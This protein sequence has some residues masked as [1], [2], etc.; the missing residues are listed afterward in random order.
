VADNSRV[1]D[2]PVLELDEAL[3]SFAT[4][5]SAA[6]GNAID[7]LGREALGGFTAPV[8]KKNL[9]FHRA[10]LLLALEPAKRSWCLD[11][12]I[13]KLP[14]LLDGKEHSSG[15]KC[16]ALVERLEVLAKLEPDPRVARGVLAMLEL[17]APVAGFTIVSEAASKAIVRHA[18]D[19]TAASP[20]LDELG[21]ELDRTKLPKPV[22]LDATVRARASA[23]ERPAKRDTAALF[24]AVYASP[25]AD[26]PREVLA[27]ALQEAGD[28]RGEFIALQLREARGDTSDELR[29]RAQ[30]LAKEHG[31][32][33]LGPLRP[34]TYRAEMRRGFVQRLE[35]AGSWSTNKWEELATE[36][37]LATV[38]EL[39][40]GQAT[41]AVYAK[42]LAGPIART[43]CA[44]AV[45]DDAVW[46]VVT[47]TAMP[48]LRELDATWWK[49]KD[50]KERFATQVLPW[51]E[52]HPQI[53]RL[54]CRLD[55][56]P[57][58]SKALVA[59]LTDLSV[60]CGIPTGAKQW[61]K[62]RTLHTLKMGL[63][64]DP[65]VLVRDGKREHARLLSTRFGT[66]VPKLRLLPKTIKRIEVVNN[67]TQAKELAK[68][69]PK[70][71]IVAV[72]PPSGTITG[73]K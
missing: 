7:T 2:G 37:M 67:A 26:E 66:P 54:A 30:A 27:D 42:F 48:R 40:P 62:L 16:E 21:D 28:P 56:L 34:I 36:P 60:D 50:Y 72:R 17:R 45:F 64:Y 53:T 29:E 43:V 44:I 5:R 10:W 18:D 49:R 12:L 71:E 38:E 3:A 13:D 11:T 23:V 31:K 68:S 1:P 55:R 8:F 52:T 15:D 33:W 20:A 46:K 57:T 6:L 63:L 25:D 14:K 35:L 4:Q 61:A 41:G 58:M 22:A 9:E 47:T 73:V 59:R 69:F 51:L 24:A 70:L 39:V 19:G 65:I 32:A